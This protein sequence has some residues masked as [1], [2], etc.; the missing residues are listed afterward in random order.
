MIILSFNR[1]ALFKFINNGHKQNKLFSR[2]LIL[3]F[4]LY[5]RDEKITQA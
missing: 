4:T 3:L 1:E 2:A 5:T